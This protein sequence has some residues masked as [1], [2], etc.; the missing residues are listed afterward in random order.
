MCC[1]RHGTDPRRD[2]IDAPNHCARAADVETA[3]SGDCECPLCA[4]I[5]AGLAELPWTD[6]LEHFWAAHVLLGAWRRELDGQRD[7]GAEIDLASE[8]AAVREDDSRDGA[9]R[10]VAAG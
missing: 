8:V 4:A 5:R 7:D 9:L 10:V 2:F 1:G 6:R 3:R